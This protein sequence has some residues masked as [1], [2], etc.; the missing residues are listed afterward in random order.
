[1]LAKHVD[2]AALR[3]GERCYG[4]PKICEVCPQGDDPRINPLIEGHVLVGMGDRLNDANV[5]FPKTESSAK[6]GF[7][8]CITG[9]VDELLP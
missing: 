3:G 2:L 7:H 9:R 8:K 6:R 5:L 1:M 4:V